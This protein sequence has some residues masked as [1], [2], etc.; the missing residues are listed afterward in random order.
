MLKGLILH[1]ETFVQSHFCAE[2]KFYTKTFLL[3]VNFARGVTFARV[4][5]CKNSNNNYFYLIVFCC[6]HHHF[7]RLPLHHLQSVNFV[8]CFCFYL[9]LLWLFFYVIYF[10]LLC[11][12]DPSC[13]SVLVQKC[14]FVHTLSSVEEFFRANST[15]FL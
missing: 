12:N 5:L 4:E 7:Y 8:A 13:K 14:S 2:E 6:L 1:N 10:L 9:F 3:G 15:S 11:W